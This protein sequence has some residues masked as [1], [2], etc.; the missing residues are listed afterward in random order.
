MQ[1]TSHNVPEYYRTTPHHSRS[2][3]PHAPFHSPTLNHFR[4]RTTFPWLI[5]Y[6]HIRAGRIARTE[7]SVNGRHGLRSDGHMAKSFCC[8]FVMCIGSTFS[9]IIWY[10]YVQLNWLAGKFPFI[11]F[12]RSFV[13]GPFTHF[14]HK[15][16]MW[17][18]GRSVV[19]IIKIFM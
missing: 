3:S 7:F 1:S 16:M 8:G 18:A 9:V 5:F 10:N 14:M 4:L 17:P 11:D 13:R 2:T 12:L 6:V 15:W 19:W